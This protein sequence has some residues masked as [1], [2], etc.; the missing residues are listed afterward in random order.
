[1]AQSDGVVNSRPGQANHRDPSGHPSL[2][3]EGSKRWPVGA[4][5]GLL[6]AACAVQPASETRSGDDLATRVDAV[7]M[8]RGLG[9]DALSVIDNVIHHEG[10][11][12]RAVPPL[13]RELLARPL[14]AADAAAL[15]ERAVPSGLRRLAR[16]RPERVARASAA[17]APTIEVSELLAAYLAELAEAQRLLRA[18]AGD[19][20]IDGDA[21]VRQFDEQGLPTAVLHRL[22]AAVEP[23]SLDRATTA[24]IDATARFVQ[25]LIERG[26]SVRFPEKAVRFD[27]PIGVVSIGTRGDD[28]HASDAAVIID[29]GGNDSYERAPATGGAISVIIDL[30][31]D[32]RYQGVDV[33]VQGFSAIVDFSGN[34]RYAMSGPG[35]GAAVF[36]ASVL[37]DFAG[38]DVYEATRFGQGAAAFGVGAIIELGGNDSYRLRASGQ[39]FG[40]ARGLGLL[41]DRGGD[42]TYA[43]GGVRDAYDRGGGISMAQG[44]AHGSRTSI[45]GGIGILRDDAGN[46][47][48]EAEMFA[49]GVGY[50]YGIGLLWDRA[51]ADRYRAVRYAQGNGVHEATGTLRDD[52]GDDRYELTFGVGQ[53]MGLDLAV[54]MLFDAAGDDR[55]QSQ[56]LAQGAATENGI[57]IAFDGGGADEWSMGA[58]PR[59]WG[60]I[61]WTGALPTLGFFLLDEPARATFRREG[62]VVPQPAPSGEAGE[63][64]GNAPVTRGASDALGCA[65]IAQDAAGSDLPLVEA[66]REIAPGYAGGT[67]DPEIQADVQRRLT[68]RLEES[69]GEISAGDFAIVWSFTRALRCAITEATSEEAESMWAVL[70]RVLRADP[71]IPLALSVVGTLRARPPPVP[72][73]KRMLRVLDEH[74]QCSVR[75]SAL[76]LRQAVST[77]EPERSTAEHAA[78]AAMRSPCW[79]LQAVGRTVLRRLDVVP[80]S[81]D[82]LPSF[83]RGGPGGPS[84]GR[85]GVR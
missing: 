84:R 26:E 13:V 15:F 62:Q 4:L 19:A 24:F 73:T 63:P 57:G 65:K 28:R 83:L 47:S 40:M 10:P 51:G 3:K 43:A 1:V 81:E 74:P 34:D 30:G 22:A 11:P 27:S 25:V 17:D 37:V 38:D 6:V 77:E 45:G 61:E 79:R 67:V 58:D 9:R 72:Q 69:I 66:L 21:I 71:G 53:G 29:P 68:T 33:A 20:A 46:D 36:G 60:R 56:V 39:G 76:L 2:S 59:S 16:L 35:L 31:G 64:E 32:D 5:A 85:A 75:A 52:A 23:A 54:G 82:N 78:R 70:E 55:Y 48:Y 42:D 14:A 41:W 12:P 18:A 44:A 80:D 50:Y 49:Q 7:L 8:R